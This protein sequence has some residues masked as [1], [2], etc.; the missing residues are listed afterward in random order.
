MR[1]AHWRSRRARVVAVAPAYAA[2]LLVANL[3]LSQQSPARRSGALG[4]SSTDV[5]NLERVP[6][7]GIPASALWATHFLAYWLIAGGG[8]V[9]G[10]A[11]LRGPPGAGVGAGGAPGRGPGG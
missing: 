9:G 5:A 10:L 6:W 1:A 7:R 3:W 4:R 11:R 2:A 8:C